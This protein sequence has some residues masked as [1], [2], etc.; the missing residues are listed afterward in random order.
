M[1]RQTRKYCF[2]FRGHNV[3]PLAASNV[4][5][6]FSKADTSANGTPTM[7]GLLGGGLRLALEAT[8][9]VQNLCLFMGDVLTFDIDEIISF[10][11]IAKTGASLNAATS[12]SFGLASARND[13]IDS[14]AAHASFR[15]IGNNNVL[16]E[17]DD[18]ATDLDDIATGLTLGTNWKRFRIDFASRN[19]TVEAPSVSRGRRS[20]IEFYGANDNG[21]QRRVASGTRFDMTNYSSG[22]QIYAQIQKTASTAADFLDILE[23]CV[24][25]NL[26][27]FS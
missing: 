7:L 17:T 21:S 8:N 1:A 22:L 5:S 9:E 2:D 24:E 16:V 23:V 15:C 10:E 19:T 12:L 4:G 25:T 26:P 14:I 3:I 11:I 13:A 18:G 27:A 20:N 6:P